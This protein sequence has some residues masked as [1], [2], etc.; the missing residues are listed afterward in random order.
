MSNPMSEKIKQKELHEIIHKVHEDMEGRY[1]LTGEDLH[2]IHYLLC[3]LQPKNIDP[4][5]RGFDDSWIH[6]V[7]MGA[8]D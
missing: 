7:D 8:R 2:T 6:D 4:R 1:D 3:G 5:D